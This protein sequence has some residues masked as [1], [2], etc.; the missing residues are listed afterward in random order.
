MICPMK[1]G[2]RISSDSR[3]SRPVL[4]RIKNA[5]FRA[6]IERTYFEKSRILNK[7]SQI[8]AADNNAR[9]NNNDR[10]N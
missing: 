3:F 6:E 4:Q 1:A 5:H 2:L 9:G 8:P 7:I 10:R